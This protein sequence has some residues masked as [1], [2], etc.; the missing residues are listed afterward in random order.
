[1]KQ[2]RRTLRAGHRTEPRHVHGGLPVIEKVQT[3]P[4]FVDVVHSELAY[5]GP[6]EGG[7]WYTVTERVENHYCATRWMREHVLA[8]IA[9][10]YENDGRPLS[11]VLSRGQYRVVISDQPVQAR[12]P[13]GRPHY[14]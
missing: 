11:S 2:L 13:E 3:V 4:C 12:D 7:W 14:E 9:A 5:G 10:R 8:S 6:E 1:M